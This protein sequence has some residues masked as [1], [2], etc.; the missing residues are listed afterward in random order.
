M[1]WEREMAVEN[2]SNRGNHIT[3]KG[4]RNNNRNNKP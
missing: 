1:A 2:P 3:W 4:E